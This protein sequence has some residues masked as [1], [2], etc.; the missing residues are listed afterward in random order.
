MERTEFLVGD[1]VECIRAYDGN[2]DIVGVTGTVCYIRE[3]GLIAV[4]YDREIS[5][6]H[7]CNARCDYG[8]GWFTGRDHL[9]LCNDADI[10]ITEPIPYE[11]LNI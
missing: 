7:D 1:R 9:I 10:P 6:G 4:E 5:F 11:S 2:D 8:Y 3:D